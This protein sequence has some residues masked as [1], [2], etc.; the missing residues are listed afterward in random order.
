[1]AIGLGDM[2]DDTFRKEGCERRLGIW[3]TKLNLVSCY[4]GVSETSPGDSLL[5][6]PDINFTILTEEFVLP[7]WRLS[8]EEWKRKEVSQWQM[9]N[10]TLS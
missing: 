3:P 5:A 8:E 2:D 9:L 4:H 6:P 10:M 7:A 1:M